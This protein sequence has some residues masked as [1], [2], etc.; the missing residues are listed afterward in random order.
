MTTK[1]VILEN[2]IKLEKLEKLYP[3]KYCCLWNGVNSFF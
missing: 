3:T 1:E 2:R